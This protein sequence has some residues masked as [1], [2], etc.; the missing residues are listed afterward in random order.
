MPLRQIAAFFQIAAAARRKFRKED[1]TKTSERSI[2]NFS[3]IK[4]IEFSKIWRFW[5]KSFHFWTFILGHYIEDVEDVDD[6]DELGLFVLFVRL[7]FL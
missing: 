5:K 2:S 3:S 4:K 7:F 1:Q 6:V